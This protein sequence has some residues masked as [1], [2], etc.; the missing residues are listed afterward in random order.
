MHVEH[1]HGYELHL[2]KLGLNPDCDTA[3]DAL[4]ATGSE[5]T[6][7]E[8]YRAYAK[9]FFEANLESMPSHGPQDLV[10]KLL[11][12]KQ[13]PWG[14]NY[15]LSQK[16]MGTPHSYLKVQLKRGYIRLSK[17]PARAPV[18]FVL[19]EDGTLRL[20]VDFRGLNQI[21][22]KNQYPLP[23]ISEAIDR[24]LGARY[25]TKLDIREAYHRL[26]IALGN[27]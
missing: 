3:R 5:P 27:E 13:P 21:T 26:G 10:I 25:F 23:L 4:M 18:F 19:K 22:K 20:Y 24:L 14:S 2:H 6:V 8:P 12:S 15:N 11:D 1:T 7:M 16:E 17:T 9:V